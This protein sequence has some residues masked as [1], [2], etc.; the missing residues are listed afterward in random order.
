MTI[1]REFLEDM[2]GNPEILIL[3]KDNV[4]LLRDWANA[5]GFDAPAVAV[6]SGATLANLYHEHYGKETIKTDKIDLATDIFVKVIQALG[7][8]NWEHATLRKFAFDAAQEYTNQK[9]FADRVKRAAL[10]IYN[11]LPPKRLE[12][13]TAHSTVTLTGNHHYKTEQ[14]L[15]IVGL[16]HPV[17]LVGPTGCGKTTLSATV[18]NALNLPFYM[19][20]SIVD[21]HQLTG[22]IDGYGKY[23]ST[24]FRKAF[25]NGGVWLADEIDAWDAS[26]LLTANSALA[27]GYTSFPDRDEPIMRHENFRVIASANTYGNGADRVYVGR[28][29]LDAASLDRFAVVTLDYDLTLE[30]IFAN[31]NDK[32]L[33]HVWKIRKQV[34]EKKI[35]HVVSSR[36]IIMGSKALANG[37]S[38]RDCENIYLFKGMSENDRKKIE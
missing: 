25:E 26:A 3:N 35:R 19:T 20:P 7:V 15:K 6:M 14:V 38:W 31:G 2:I 10:D 27:N 28:T 36:A 23:H 11:E 33:N 34:I 4:A 9:D 12:I 5:A 30:R 24:P 29:E 8:P 1:T 16:N 18:A 21:G 32:W 37:L 13:I 22:F 17:N